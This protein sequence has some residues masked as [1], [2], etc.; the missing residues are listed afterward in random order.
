MPDD[1]PVQP[2]PLATPVGKLPGVGK[3][4][5]AALKRL[6]IHSL[7]DLLRHLPLRYQFEHAESSIAQLPAEGI[8]SARGLIAALRW[9]PGHGPQGRGKARLEVTLEDADR[10][11]NV[12]F[13]NAGYLRERLH[14]GLAIRVQGKVG[15]FQG[16]PQMVNPRWEVLADV[17][18]APAKQEIFRPV[19]PAT[20][21]LSSR[22]IENLLRDLL[23]RALAAV[24]DP[25]PAELLTHHNMPDLAQAYQLA[26]QPEDEDDAKRARRRL[27]YNELLLL[28]LGTA[29]KRHYNQT[30]LLAP[31]LRWTPALD[32]HIRQRFGFELTDSQRQVIGHIAADLQKSAPMNRLVQGDVGAGKTVVALYALLM[33]VAAGK[34]GAL[35][36]PTELLAEQH[37][38]T[39]SRM[40]AG[41]DV[42]VALV[43]AGRGS[44]RSKARQTTLAQIEAG[45]VDLVIGTQALVTEQVRF[46][47]LAVVVVDEQHRFGVLQRA[48][49]RS[50]AEDGEAAQDGRR[51]SP[52][53]LVM[54]ATPIPRTL[55]LALFGDLEV[56][57]IHGL[58]PG[59]QP[60]VT[61]VV[62]P[63]QAPQVYEYV[64]SRLARGERAYVVVPVIEDAQEDDAGRAGLT[65]LKSV[66]AH[67]QL[68]ESRYFAG[69]QVAQLH[70]RMK[71]AERDAVM[72]DFR[73]GKAQVLVATTVIEVGVDVPEAT[74]MVVEHAERFGLAQLHQLRGRIGRGSLPVKNLCVFI[75]EP[76][77]EGAEQRMAAIAQT[78]DGFRI[79][80]HD[81]EIRGIGDFF[82]TRQHGAP[83]LRVARIPDDIPLLKLA[84]RDARAMVQ[85]D[86]T[87]TEPAL[88]TLRRLLLQQYG[89]ALGLIDVG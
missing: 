18:Q 89:D 19:Y 85:R 43:A 88:R 61:R 76:G 52:H 49:F 3:A 42:S 78:T 54:T 56:S 36:A 2:L 67:A 63:E 28:Q 46:S 82:G 12:V 8:G 29:L 14:P 69:Y 22:V 68:L 5:A 38:L 15:S 6:S 70:G 41:S 32:E 13:F 72:A 84:E 48:A 79:A 65:P 47:N 26:H 80:E 21:D 77:N 59:R 16:Y 11:L 53:Y 17:E 39:I 58:P 40:L 71:P 50:K 30:R 34:Q 27:A 9:H 87:L 23:P 75:A 20:E 35:M 66:A 60:I 1:A 31:Q 4:R 51:P 45:E 37:F 55:S 64:A 57:T 10:R 81:L 62:S 74:L 44:A 24:V 33:A 7:A 83:P 86:P 25:L 73:S